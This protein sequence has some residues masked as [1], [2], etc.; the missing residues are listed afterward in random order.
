MILSLGTIKLIL[1]RYFDVRP[2]QLSRIKVPMIILTSFE[3]LGLFVSGTLFFFSFQYF[4]TIVRGSKLGAD[5]S[6]TWLLDEF[7][8]M[9][10]T[11][12]N[13]LRRGSPPTQPRKDSTSSLGGG[14]ENGDPHHRHYSHSDR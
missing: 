13:S 8:T 7:D 4:Q 6:L 2:N 5:G 11:R 9:S 12:S 10:V 14:Q 1:N 3:C